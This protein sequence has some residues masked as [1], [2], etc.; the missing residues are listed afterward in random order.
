MSEPK[1]QI[2]ITT[3]ATKFLLS[4]SPFA[5]ADMM[6]AIE[7]NGWAKLNARLDA[8]LAENPQLRRQSDAYAKRLQKRQA[9]AFAKIL[10]HPTSKAYRDY[11]MVPG[12]SDYTEWRRENLFAGESVDSLMDAAEAM[13]R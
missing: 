1:K 7:P 13:E 8:M 4:L 3:Q 2:V 12:V 5:Y 11:V 6:R 9:K 10:A